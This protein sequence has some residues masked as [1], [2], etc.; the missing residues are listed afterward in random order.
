MKTKSCFKKISFYVCLFITAIFLFSF[1]AFAQEK[2]L[3]KRT[4]YKSETV[5]FGA[6][7]TL[8]ISGAPLG[9]ISVEGWNKNQIEISADIE[10]QAENEA[11][12]AE[13]AKLDGFVIDN[14]FGHIRVLT[15]GTHDKDYLKR[16]AKKFPKRLLGMPF[17]IDYRIKVPV[18]CDL[19]I[20]GGKGDF[21]LSNIQGAMQ[22]KF[23]ESNAKMNLT[24]G[25]MIATFGAGNVEM[26]VPT[27]SWRG[28]SLDIQVAAGNL[29]VYLQPV[30]DADIN[31]AVLRS[32][33]I[34]NAIASLKPRNNTKFSEKSVTA[35]NGGGGAVFNFTVGDGTLKMQN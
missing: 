2:T 28:R 23:L 26:T 29:N 7:G 20:N 14:D 35:R 16:V 3:V 13:L 4:T 32:G 6:G 5:D 18:Y 15:V 30:F 19:E 22:I 9:S 24:G 8:T 31:A 21:N 27:R 34:E 25:N 17:K 12:L 33:K 1:S 11:D 10:V